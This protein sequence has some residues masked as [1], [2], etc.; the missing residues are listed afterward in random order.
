MSVSEA[1]LDLFTKE[2]L[3]TASPV[4]LSSAL[5]S[6]RRG[7]GRRDAGVSARRAAAPSRRVTTMAYGDVVAD[8]AILVGAVSPGPA[9][10]RS[11]NNSVSRGAAAL[12]QRR[13][14]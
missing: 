7:T 8:P 3:A 13:P 2:M 4:S 9:L 5:A 12:I 11:V 10:A 14:A 6:P 1:T